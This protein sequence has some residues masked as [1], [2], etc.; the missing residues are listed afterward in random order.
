MTSTLFDQQLDRIAAGERLAAET[1]RELAGAPDL[2]PLGML[3]DTLRRRLHG[4][5]ATYV[6][7]A[8]C[9]FDASFADGTPVRDSHFTMPD[10]P[11]VG[12]EAKANLYEVM[13]ALAS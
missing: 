12:F 3:A 5:R 13:K 8:T 9:P 11:G 6:R 2:L 10:I 4:T 7:V 1:V